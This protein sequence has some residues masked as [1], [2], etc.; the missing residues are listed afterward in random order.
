MPLKNAVTQDLERRGLSYEL[1]LHEGEV[2]TLEQAAEERGMQPEQIIRT[3]VFRLEDRSYVIVMMPGHKRVSWPKLRRALGVSRI[4]T[5]HE[6][7]VEAITGYQPG[8]V[9]P[10]GLSQSLRLFVDQEVANH[11]VIS[12]GAGIRN[13]G[14]KL[15]S[16]DLLVSLNPEMGDFGE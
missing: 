16:E 4:R 9:S 2:H 1:H 14:V 5:A 12:V 13:A 15:T 3:L 10:F 11:E 7:E 8:A 6:Q